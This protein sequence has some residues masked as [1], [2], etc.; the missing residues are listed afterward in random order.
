MV[1]LEGCL[2]LLT[3]NT[4][5]QDFG[6]GVAAVAA[7]DTRCYTAASARIS[8]QLSSRF[9]H[10][11]PP[12]QHTSAQPARVLLGEVAGI[13]AVMQSGDELGGAVQSWGELRRAELS[14]DCISD[15]L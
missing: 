3:F 12:L 1:E 10:G 4:A 13:G 14:W 11:A 9:M 15:W 5:G 8:A 6:L 7:D 2:G